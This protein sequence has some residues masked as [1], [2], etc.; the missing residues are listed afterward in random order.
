VEEA[1]AY[2]PKYYHEAAELY[3]RAGYMDRALYMNSLVLDQTVKTKQRFN[4]LLEQ[5]RYEE[6]MA[7]EARLKRLG[8]LNEDSMR[9]AMAY[10]HFNAQHFD[11]ASA[12]LNQISSSG[13]F[14][15]ASQLRKAIE[16]MR[17][18]DVEFF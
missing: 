3:R 9:Y 1:A 15:E 8:A 12:Y 2:E 6:A 5:N 13:F 4:L 16:M 11:E 10:V 14:R 18:R 17:N 7:L